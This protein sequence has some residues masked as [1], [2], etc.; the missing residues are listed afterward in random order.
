MFQEKIWQ[1]DHLKVVGSSQAGTGTCFYLPQ[2]GCCFDLGHGYPYAYSAKTY[3][4]THAHMDHAGGIAYVISQRAL[5]KMNIG[6]FYMPEYMIEPLSQILQLWSKLEGHTY[7][8]E[9]LP[10]APGDTIEVKKNIFVRPIEAYHRVPAQ[11]YCV[12]ERKKKL[13]N[14]Y[15]GLPGNK[16]GEL[17]SQGIPIENVSEEPVFCFSGDTK[18]E[19]LTT[20]ADVSRARVLL[21]E[22]TYLDEKRDVQN[23]RQWG[24]LHLDE[25]IDQLDYLKNEVILLTHVSRKY[26]PVEIRKIIEKKIPAHQ[27][28][29]VFY[30]DSNS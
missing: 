28:H 12:Y 9:F 30:F 19:F 3:F 8:F 4:L 5:N 7:D 22:V 10:L 25:L 27:K 29:R 26:S 15:I 17:K 18:S 24:H 1:N 16:I 21:T 13:K 20:H 14:E 23:C 11:G 2:Y 6:R